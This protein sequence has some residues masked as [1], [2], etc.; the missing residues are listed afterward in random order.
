MSKIGYCP[1]CDIA[2]FKFTNGN[3]IKPLGN[4]RSIDFLRKDGSKI[5]VP[6]CDVCHDSMKDPVDESFYKK[7]FDYCLS[8][9]PSH[10]SQEKKE[11]VSKRTA[12]NPIASI[13]RKRGS[14]KRGEAENGYK[15]WK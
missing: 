8:A 13:L 10:W 1:L 14:L 11:K 12:M 4:Y 15:I 2:I 5:E 7:I 9:C 3:P 6:M